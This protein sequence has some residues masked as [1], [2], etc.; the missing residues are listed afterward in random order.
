MIDSLITFST[1]FILVNILVLGTYNPGGESIYHWITGHANPTDAWVV[2]IGVV[3]V[4]LNVAVLMAAWKALGVIG[5]ALSLVLLGAMAYVSLQ[6]SAVVNL[7][8]LCLAL[9]CFYLGIGVSGA[10]LWRRATG[11]VVVEDAENI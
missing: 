3:T 7:Q 5:T 1:R 4:L 8:W 9:Y 11:Q 10:I 6:E 2:L